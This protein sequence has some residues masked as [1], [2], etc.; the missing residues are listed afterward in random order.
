MSKENFNLI[1]RLRE[2]NLEEKE[3]FQN[4]KKLSFSAFGTD[5]VDSKIY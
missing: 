3:S 4:K 5:E 2:T 1:Q